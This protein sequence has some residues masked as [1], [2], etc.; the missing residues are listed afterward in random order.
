ML[1]ELIPPSLNEISHYALPVLQIVLGFVQMKE[2]FKFNLEKNYF[3]E[4]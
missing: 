2:P 1:E 3:L 4:Y